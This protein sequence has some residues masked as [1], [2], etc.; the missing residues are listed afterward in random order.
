MAVLKYVAYLCEDP[1]KLAKF[2]QEK[3]GLKQS[4]DAVMGE[5]TN[6]FGFT[7]GKMDLVIMDHPKV[8]G[9][10]KDGARVV[11]NLEVDD[12][13]KDFKKLKKA[14][15]KVIA[16]IYHIQDYGYLATFADLDGNHFQLVKTKA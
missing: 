1:E 4:W 6:V 2:Y 14:G 12:I 15:A 5:D 11:F 3:V 7:I 16:E 9:K 13:E 8:K 10:S